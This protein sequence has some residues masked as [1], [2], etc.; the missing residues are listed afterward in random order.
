MFLLRA[1]ELDFQP[2]SVSTSQET[3]DQLAQAMA[4]LQDQRRQGKKKHREETE[5][6][7]KRVKELEMIE[8]EEAEAKRKTE[9]EKEREPTK[10]PEGEPAGKLIPL[11]F[12]M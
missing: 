11:V 7:E 6:L 8:I 12:H 2:P 9:K 4:R 5:A 3:R 1:S 10:L